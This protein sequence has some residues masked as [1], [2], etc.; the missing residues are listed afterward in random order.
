MVGLTQMRRSL[1]ERP[2][3]IQNEVAAVSSIEAEFW[4]VASIRPQVIGPLAIGA[5][6]RMLDNPSP[7]KRRQVDASF[8]HHVSGKM[9]PTFG[10][11]ERRRGE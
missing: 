6:R 4:A 10:V 8:V 9:S 3:K 5:S 1:R 2:D 7:V 11:V